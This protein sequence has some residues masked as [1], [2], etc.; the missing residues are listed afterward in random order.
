MNKYFYGLP[1]DI[2]VNID[3]DLEPKMYIECKAYTENAM[4]KRILFDCA[5]AKR[6]HPDILFMLFQLESHLGGDYKDLKKESETVGSY[7]TRA[8]LSL[9]DIDL[10]IVTL[11]KGERS[12][13]NPIHKKFKPLEWENLEKIL[14]VLKLQL[15]NFL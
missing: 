7:S 10:R 15:K 4:L 8:I 9:S 11:L 14:E 2:L 6:M 1:P 3:I 5:V 12:I 13:Q